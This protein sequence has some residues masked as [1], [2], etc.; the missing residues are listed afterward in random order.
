[1]NELNA[2]NSVLGSN[3]AFL[4]LKRTVEVEKRTAGAENAQLELKNAQ[5]G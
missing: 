4:D 3:C 2:E 5:L 1:M